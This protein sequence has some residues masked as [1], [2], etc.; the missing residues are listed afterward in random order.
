MMLMHKR[1]ASKL[2]A[3]KIQRIILNGSFND[4]KMGEVISRMTR[5]EV[6]EQ[7][8]EPVDV[9][10]VPDIE[11]GEVLVDTRGRGSLQH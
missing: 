2:Q 8:H 4:K 7:L 3:R 9:H 11:K 10:L 1:K 6:M 5:S